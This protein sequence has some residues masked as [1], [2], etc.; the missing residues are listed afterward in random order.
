MPIPMAPLGSSTPTFTAPTPET[1]ATPD[2]A[3]TAVAVKTPSAQEIFRSPDGKWQVHINVRP[4]LDTPTENDLGYDE[5]RVTNLETGAEILADEQ[6]IYCGGLG[7]FG[8]LGYGWSAN[9]R[10]FYYTSARQGVPDGGG[11]WLKPY[12]YLDTETLQTVTLGGAVR[13]PDEKLLATSQP[14]AI[15][16]WDWNT[17]K[18]ARYEFDGPTRMLNSLV[19]SPDGQSLALLR[20]ASSFPP[21]DSYLTVLELPALHVVY[22]EKFP[23]ADF[24]SM[25]A[26]P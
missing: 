24:Q 3:A 7:A 12:H 25:R 26:A 8:F 22:S 16:L 19:W 4:C 13:S 5:L 18:V 15:T 20:T 23:E 17:G 9:S 14:D 11:F 10:Y 2:L 1:G 6:L 21:G